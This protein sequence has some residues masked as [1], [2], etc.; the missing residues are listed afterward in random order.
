MGCFQNI[1]RGRYISAVAV[2]RAELGDRVSDL[3]HKVEE[4]LTHS[5][6][7]TVP[8]FEHLSSLR[9][10]LHLHVSDITRVG[11]QNS[12]QAYFEHGDKKSKLLAMLA[13]QDRPLAVILEILTAEGVL[14]T[15]QEDILSAFTKFYTSLYV[16]SLPDDLDTA[17]MVS[18]LDTLAL[19]WL[20]DAERQFLVSEITSEEVTVAIRSFPAGK[21]PGPDGLPTEYYRAH[22]EL[23]APKLA[24]MFQACLQQGSLPST[25]REAH[26]VLIPK[27]NKDP[28]LCASYR[29]IALLNCDLKILTKLLAARLNKVI[30]S[31]INSD[32][33]G[34]MPGRSTD[35]NTRRLFSN[36]HAPH[37]NQG[38][39]TI[40]TLDMEKAFDTVEW[41]YLWEVLRRMGFPLKFIDWIRT[42]YTGPLAC[43]KINGSLSPPFPL[44]RGTIQGCPFSPALFALAME[45]I[46][47]A[48]RSSAEVRGL[49]VAWLEERVA[50]Y[51]DDLLLFFNDAGD[52]LRGA[53]GV[54]DAFSAF[55]GLRVNWHKSQLFP[56]DEG[57][58]SSSP[59]STPLQW[60]DKFTYLGIIISRESVD[61]ARLNLDP[62]L[63]VRSKLKTWSNL[64]LSLIGRINLLKI[65]VLPKLTYIFRNSPQ[66][67]TKTFFNSLKQ[68]FLSFIW[69]SKPPRFRYA[70]LTRPVESGG[71]ALPDCHKYFLATQLVTTHWWLQPDLN[72]SVTVLEAAMVGSL[73]ALK[74]LLFRG[75]KIPHSLTPTPSMR[76]TM[77]VWKVGEALRAPQPNF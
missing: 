74:G 14:V 76:T 28:N 43:I 24:Q 20:S 63:A 29:P 12:R 9:R 58:M 26:I 32:Q 48:L 50:L 49:R 52:S 44:Q 38:I 25:M 71:L 64:P 1:Q 45:P 37:T 21:T 60:V 46:A 47:E 68:L 69:E 27:P 67:L 13:Q 56:V 5:A 30:K 59:S 40:A 53:L 42:L 16:S 23:L 7:A 72:N 57:A 4:A 19:G 6:S 41:V 62:V 17:P 70:T 10:E 51:A 65:K 8:N 11:I 22:I 15:S 18:M 39:R 31:L 77:R 55:T 73:E 3:Q 35:I 34:F 54:M 2:V 61:F 36:I 66:W 33:T 75:P